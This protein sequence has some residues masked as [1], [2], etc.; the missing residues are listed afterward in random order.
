VIERD[1]ASPPDASV[2]RGVALHRGGPA[3]VRLARAAGP[4]TLVQRGAE[5][6]LAELHVARADRGVTLASADG[7]IRVDLVE[8]LFAALGG[9]GVGAGVQIAIDDDELPLLDGGALRFAEAV[10]ALGLANEP[11][12]APAALVITRHASIAR[13]A[14]LYDF[15]PGPDIALR[16]EVEFRAPV[17]RE[18]AEWRGDA[19][20]FLERI[21][22]ARTFGWADEHAA[23]LASGRAT[24]VDLDAVLV[25]DE[26]GA[27]SGCRPAAKDECARHKLLDL[28]G[29]LAIHGGPPRGSIT[30][31]HPGHAAT[32]AVVAEAL[33]LG[34]LVRSG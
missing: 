1:V 14:A 33:A 2:L 34:V 7:R 8:H 25:F 23:L 16:V 29:D 13:G 31:S 18:S 12:P 22:P 32:H 17:G 30:A 20:D 19:A 9:L 28:I 4:I 5:A 24:A 15:A 11:A 3:A 6:P 21:A 10:L 26:R 27:I